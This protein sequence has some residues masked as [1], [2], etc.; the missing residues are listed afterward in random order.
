MQCQNDHEE[1]S[2]EH[3]HLAQLS[4]VISQPQ[5]ISLHTQQ[6]IPDSVVGQLFATATAIPF[7]LYKNKD[8]V[9]KL[10]QYEHQNSKSLT[11]ASKLCS[12]NNPQG[13]H[14]YIHKRASKTTQSPLPKSAS[15]F[16]VLWMARRKC[17]NQTF[18]TPLL[19]T[20]EFLPLHL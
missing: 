20:F 6:S 16:H 1:I 13:S 4:P 15:V 11:L 2:S 10:Y 9:A 12:E 5:E 3:L 7:P 17:P 8:T 18:P 14:T 19:N